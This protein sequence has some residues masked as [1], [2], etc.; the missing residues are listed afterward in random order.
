VNVIKALREPTKAMLDA[1]AF[2]NNAQSG[3]YGCD[4]V[5]EILIDAIIGDE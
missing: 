5:W 1:G 2:I 4:D 3:V